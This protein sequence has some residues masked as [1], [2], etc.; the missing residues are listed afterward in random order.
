MDFKLIDFFSVSK[1][2]TITIIVMQTQAKFVFALLK[3]VLCS[4]AP[5]LLLKST[6]GPS[7]NTKKL[8]L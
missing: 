3:L 6:V 1:Q 5:T 7:P 4:A 2:I 8:F